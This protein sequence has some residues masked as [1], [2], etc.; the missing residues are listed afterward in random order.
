MRPS[1]SSPPP[2]L[3]KERAQR[4]ARE[5][6]EERQHEEG[7]RI[8]DVGDLLFHAASATPEGHQKQ[9]RGTISGLFSVDQAFAPMR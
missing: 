7:V 6:R 9:L 4:D 1:C 8:D 2:V 5:Q 3:E